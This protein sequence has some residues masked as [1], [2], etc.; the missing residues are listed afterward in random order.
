MPVITYSKTP[1]IVT[2]PTGGKTYYV[3]ATNVSINAQNRLEASRFL[4]PNQNNNFR[5]G[6]ELNSKINVTFVACNQNKLGGFGSSSTWNFASGVL[7]DFTGQYELVFYIGP[8]IFSGCYLESASV[9]ITP[10]A[11]VMISAEFACLIPPANKLFSG[12]GLNYLD[13]LNNGIAYGFNTIITDGSTL[14]DSN[15]E[16]IS[17]KIN[18]N[19]TYT[20]SIG[21]TSPNNVFLNGVEKELSIKSH[22]IGAYIDFTG[23]GEIINIDPKNNSG[24]SVVGGG[25]GMSSDCKIIAQNLS[26]QEGDV[27]AGD[28]SLKE[29][30]L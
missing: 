5:I 7:Q 8:N 10:F 27:L 29:I 2:S 20:T 17:Y 1:I 3:P 22:N 19:R 26:V 15:R 9:E 4:A 18:C 25:F 23:Y 24:Q 28:I 30:I 13:D 6:G 21:Y 16:N 14:S 12:S 11:P